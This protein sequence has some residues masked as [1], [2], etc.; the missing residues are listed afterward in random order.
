MGVAHSVWQAEKLLFTPCAPDLGAIPIIYAFPNTYTVGITS[1][2]YQH[3]W[4]NLASR[5]EVSVSRWFTDIHEPLP[6]EVELLGFSF[7][8]ELDYGN[9]LYAL[10]VLGVPWHSGDRTSGHPLV[11]GGGAV[12]TANPEPFAEWFDLILLGDGEDLLG[13]LLTAYQGVRHAPRAE[14]LL[15]LA[16]VPGVYVPSLYR[17]VYSHATGGIHSIEPVSTAVPAT[18]QKQTYKGNVLSH[19][20][21]VTPHAAWADIFMVEVV[22]SC[23]EMCR[24]CL[25]SYL[26]LPFR[27]ADL[28][29]GLLP[30]IRQGLSVTNRLGLLGA[31][32][33]QHPEFETLLDWLDQPEFDSVRLS[34][35]SVRTN[36]LTPRLCRILA[37]HDSRSVTVAVESGSE[38]LRQIINKKLSNEQI[39]QAI[40]NAQAGGLQGIKFY[41]MVGVPYETDAD[42]ADTVDMLCTAKQL[43]PK[44]KIAFGCSTFVP[45]AHTPWQ[46]QGV[47]PSAEKKLQFLQKQL[48]KLGIDFRPENYRDSVVQALISRGD[49][50]LHAVLTLAYHYAQADGKVEPSLGMFKRAFKELAETVPP[51]DWYVFRTWGMAE[52]LPWTHLRTA[53]SPE[54]LQ[55]HHQLALSYSDSVPPLPAV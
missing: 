17:V 41:G 23:P 26:T 40:A 54:L 52:V 53:L 1:L 22:R 4:A 49:R 46:W 20:S 45:K 55:K 44:L 29:V 13:N 3:I 48:G 32:I 38:R 6:R 47:S 7:S 10:E 11:F 51:L 14:Q 24:F 30:A 21:V 43:A 16:Q 28:E 27:P 33:T 9:V 50:R 42:I 5:P 8:W 31:S 36:T 34:L 18:V 15:T 25:A 37:R 2:G 19:S 35:A 39:Y 12:L